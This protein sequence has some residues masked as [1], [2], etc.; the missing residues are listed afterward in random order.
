MSEPILVTVAPFIMEHEARIAAAELSEAGIAT[1]VT[2]CEAGATFGT[3]IGSAVGGVRLQVAEGDVAA[4]SQILAR[5]HSANSSAWHCDRCG[6][7]IESGFAVC[8]NCEAEAQQNDGT[9][10]EVLPNSHDMT[11]SL[12]DRDATDALPQTSLEAEIQ[13]NDDLAQK[14]FKM[15]IFSCAFV[16]IILLAFPQV[17][18]VASLELSPAGNRRFLAALAICATVTTVWFLILR[19]SLR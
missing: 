8:W 19:M 15:A 3:Y 18:R 7:D 17:F 11:K 12:E 5:I 10:S 13:A 16:P 9:Q 14:A 6:T 1:I 4:A 2:D